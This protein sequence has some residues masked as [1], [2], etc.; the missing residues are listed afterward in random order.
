M[1]DLYFGG[2]EVTSF[3]KLLESMGVN[4]VAASYMGYRRRIKHM[5]K[6]F[7]EDRFGEKTK[8]LLDSG[9]HAFNHAPDQQYSDEELLQIAA[10][11]DAFVE[12]NIDR[13]HL[14]TEFDA[15]Q[16]GREWIANRRGHEKQIVVWHEEDGIELL[17]ELCEKHA[18]V[19]VTGTALGDRD[20]TP[21]LKRVAH[22]GTELYGLGMSKPRQMADIPWTGITST[23]WISPV[24]FRDLIVWVGHELKRYPKKNRESGKRRHRALMAHIGID[25]D[26]IDDDDGN[27]LLKLSV[28]S[29]LQQIAHIN[30]VELD[31][32]V[33]AIPT[34][35]PLSG[36]AE[37]EGEDVA[38]NHGR[39]RNSGAL[40]D[41]PTRRAK[42]TI[43]GMKVEEK[44]ESYT[45]SGGIPRTRTLKLVQSTNENLRQCTGCH[46][47][48]VCPKFDPGAECAFEIPADAETP[49][50]RRSQMDY[51][52]NRQFERTAFGLLTEEVGG[53]YPDGN[54]S[55]EIMLYSRLLKLQHDM[56]QEGFS[57]TIR[58]NQRASDAQSG[59][60]VLSRIFGRDP[61]ERAQRAELPEPTEHRSAAEQ[62]G[63]VDAEVVEARNDDAA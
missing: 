30:G 48:G 27:E 36:N 42:Q 31:K 20:L 5:D 11:Y 26:L 10:E 15:Q 53:G 33:V 59:A 35:T 58:A 47:Q 4:T 24:K 29:W 56:D 51:L 62:L 23:S 25:P 50:E 6:V 14:F 34:S 40:G 60:G 55:R 61:V 39:V 57:L 44:E 54:I 7:L 38:S 16:L 45:D 12:R 13:I 1:L 41:G 9:C 3:T 52:I 22:N 37:D 63:I 28:W 49:A 2:G 32:E 43:P 18:R 8:I 21:V 19:A 17:E 46:M